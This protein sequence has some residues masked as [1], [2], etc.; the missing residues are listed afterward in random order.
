MQK[1]YYERQENVIRHKNAS[2]YITVK[3]TKTKIYDCFS[4]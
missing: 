3:N 4:V 2:I 1:K